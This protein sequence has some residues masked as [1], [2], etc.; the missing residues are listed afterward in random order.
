MCWPPPI[1]KRTRF[2]LR[3][4]IGNPWNR[5]MRGGHQRNQSASSGRPGRETQRLQQACPRQPCA[6]AASGLDH[7]ASSFG[8]AL[9]SVVP[10]P[11]GL[12]FWSLRP[13]TTTPCGIGP[14]IA[15]P[16]QRCH[17]GPLTIVS[18]RECCPPKSA[19][20]IVPDQES[21]TVQE[22]F[23]ADRSVRALALN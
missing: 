22:E 8:N 18:S 20:Q 19:H 10:A 17:S 7:L 5:L 3:T 12:R 13:C 4:T 16:P 21:R 11:S 15:F 14:A 1:R 6:S 9:S 2:G 23:D